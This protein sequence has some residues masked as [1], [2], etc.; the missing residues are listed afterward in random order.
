MRSIGPFRP[1][2]LSALA[3][4]AL[5]TLTVA[6]PAQTV[7]PP[8]TQAN[9]AENVDNLDFACGSGSVAQPGTGTTAIGV[10][11]KAN[12]DATTA[13]GASAA[14][15][16]ISAIAVGQN[17]VAS[18]TGSVA[19]GQGAN[20][21]GTS[22]VAIGFAARGLANGAIAISDTATVQ[23][24]NG[25]AIGNGAAA[26]GAS[27]VALG[28]GAQAPNAN[29][30]VLGTATNLLTAPG[31]AAAASKAAQQGQVLMVTIDAN[32]NLAAAP[33]PVCRCRPVAVGPKGGVIVRPT[34]RPGAKKQ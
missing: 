18:G 11:A 3:G 26:I 29:Q 24:A 15:S 22:S 30:M 21:T 33:V 2:F 16:S 34:V 9:C 4:S 6:A 23:G 14:A 7:T 27:S 17:S 13:I 12:G 32:G 31:I 8:S 10:N 19:V 20:S 5:L 28:A 25:I 1:A